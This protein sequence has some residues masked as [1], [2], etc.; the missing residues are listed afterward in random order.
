MSNFG[1]LVCL[2]LVAIAISIGTLGVSIAALVAQNKHSAAADGTKNDDGG[3]AIV[4]NSGSRMAIEM[5][6]VGVEELSA[7]A[8][9]RRLS[10]FGTDLSAFD[11]AAAQ[12]AHPGPLRVARAMAIINVAM[13]D[14][15][16]AST[17]LFQPYSG[18]LPFVEPTQ[19]VS[20]CAA[21]A[22]AGRLTMRALYPSFL[23]RIEAEVGP[24]L[25]AVVDGEG[26]TRGIEVGRRAAEL[27]L[28]ERQGDGSDHQ[29]P[30]AVSFESSQVG[31]WRRDPIAQH[32]V[33]LGAFWAQRVSPFVID[34]ASQF[35]APPPASLDSARFRVELDE[36]RSVGGDNVT[37]PT[38]RDEWGSL[39]GVYW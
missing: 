7:R 16:A 9:F 23:Q 15:V 13:S 34:T 4:V 12:P 5:A 24:I 29:E 1:A 11:A 28:A 31:A 30:A 8:A 38:A 10:L 26:K 2:V 39:V 37:T 36:V 3:A 17:R 20:I 33:A 27:I 19:V 21:V 14:A 22:T 35:R 18:S 25:A 6:A 32:G